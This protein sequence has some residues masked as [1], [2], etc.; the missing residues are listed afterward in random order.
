MEIKATLNKP[1]TEQQ[2]IDFIVSENHQKGYEIKETESALEAWG[3]TAE[4][5][6]EQE[7]QAHKKE[8]MVQLDELDLK[9]IRSLRAI[10]AGTST[11]AD[12]AK[13]AELEEQAE[14]IRQELKDIANPIID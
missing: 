6:A 7:K 5:I 12:T 10:Q 11:E 8:L 13:L 9:A 2:R 1:Y 3:L 14:Q 4:E